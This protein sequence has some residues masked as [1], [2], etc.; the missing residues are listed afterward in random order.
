MRRP[1]YEPVRTVAKQTGPRH[2]PSVRAPL[3]SAK[4]PCGPQAV[5][6]SGIFGRAILN[7]HVPVE[8]LSSPAGKEENTGN[9][10]KFSDK[11]TIG[12]EEVISTNP[13]KF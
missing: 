8:S 11:L 3:L 4:S 10:S 13:V 1:G 6:V 2:V 9:A 7:V 5:V 12:T